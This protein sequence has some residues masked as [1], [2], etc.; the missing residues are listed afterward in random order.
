MEDLTNNNGEMKF[1]QPHTSSLIKVIGVGGAGSNAVNHMYRLGIDGVD[2]IICNTDAKDLIKS[3]IANRV[4]LGVKLTEG[5]G[6]GAKPE[7]GKNAAIENLSDVKKYLTDTTKMVFITAGMGGGTGTGAAPVVASLAKEMNILTVGIVTIPFSAEGKIKRKHA[8]DGIAKMRESVDTLII[9]CNDKLREIHGSLPFTQAF[10]KADDVLATAARAIAEII[11]T[12]GIIT[13]DFNDVH[14]V[15]ENG[16]TAIMGTAMAEG[17]N[18]AQK[19][20]EAAL[21]S[22]LLNDNNINGASQVLLSVTTGSNEATM[23][24]IGEIQDY[25]QGE[26]GDGAN[27][28]LGLSKD[29]SLGDAIK[30]IVIATGFES[31][32]N[33]GFEPA[34]PVEKKINVLTEDKPVVNEVKSEAPSP[35]HQEAPKVEMSAPPVVPVAVTPQYGVADE[36]GFIL[37]TVSS[38]TF[39]A[40]EAKVEE[41][42]SATIVH[43]LFEEETTVEPAAELFNEPAPMLE[44]PSFSEAPSV[45]EFKAEVEEEVV[46]FNVFESFTSELNEDPQTGTE[47]GNEIVSENEQIVS[48]LLSEEPV[49]EQTEEQTSIPFE[50]VTASEEATTTITMTSRMNVEDEEETSAIQSK[51]EEMDK[52]VYNLDGDQIFENPSRS[53]SLENKNQERISRLKGLNSFLKTRAGLSELENEPAFKR[54]GIVLKDVPHSSESQVSKFTLSEGENKNIEIKPNNS[55]LHDNVD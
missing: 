16:G 41:Q 4:Q 53:E 38:E 10:S 17:D 44:T 47:T 40:E 34:K 15:M 24:E 21:S 33:L 9:V 3:P 22:P 1:E 6:A 29:E 35:L 18:R 36:H 39:V 23:D 20:V 25:I 37:K 12:T 50:I 45:E 55:F 31:S 28:I 30:L 43:H 2:F 5:R 42:P 52:K 46:A 54:K 27:I 51:F 13:V 19:V 49:A 8:E 32:K 26:A 11:S 48:E 7:V 14:T